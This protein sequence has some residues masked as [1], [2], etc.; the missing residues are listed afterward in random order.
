MMQ[1]V[2]VLVFV[3]EDMIEAAADVVGDAG[4]G[5]HLRPVQK[6]VAEVEDVPLLLGLDI[7]RKEVFEFRGPARAPRI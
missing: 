2:R 3:D 6:K 4:V 1:T 5:H 7:G